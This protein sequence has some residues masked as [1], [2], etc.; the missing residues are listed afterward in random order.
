M[1]GHSC[2][3]CGKH[4]PR[5][6]R[7][8]VVPRGLYPASKKDSRVQRL[9]VPA[10]RRCNSRWADDEVHFRNVLL[11]SGKPNRPVQ[12]LWETTT[13][14]SF[15][16]VDGRRRLLDLYAQMIPIEAPEGTRHMVYPARDERVMRIIRKIVR[17]LCHHHGIMSPVHDR[18]VRADVLK[19]VVPAEFLAEMSYHHLE[20]DIFEYRY[21]VLDESGIHSAWLL[22][23]FERRTFI[24][25][26][27]PLQPLSETNGETGD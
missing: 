17:G 4:V 11:V 5:A 1:K 3:Y 12:E 19:Y 20:K 2:A 13:R 24:A 23:F 14:R 10:C 8:H 22:T 7:E 25:T 15:Q 27:A 9:T 18:Q 26:V 21:A 16:K 6:E